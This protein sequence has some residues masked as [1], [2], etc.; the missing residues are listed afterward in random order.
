M[1]SNTLTLSLSKHV[2]PQASTQIKPLFIDFRSVFAVQVGCRANGKLIRI[3]AI[4]AIDAKR[5]E[6]AV[7]RLPVLPNRKAEI[8]RAVTGLLYVIQRAVPAQVD[9]PPPDQEPTETVDAESLAA[10]KELRDTQWVFYDF[11]EAWTNLS[12]KARDALTKRVRAAGMSGSDPDDLIEQFA[13]VADSM[14]AAAE[15]LEQPDRPAPA[16][17]PDDPALV[18]AQH[19]A[20]MYT[21]MTGK[22]APK[23]KGNAG[24][25]R[26]PFYWLL[27]DVFAAAGILASPDHYAKLI[28]HS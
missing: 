7:H 2:L 11:R 25:P 14:A 24:I 8:D 28:S 4:G 15:A 1:K 17:K 16:P 5:L 13:S 18:I 19:A 12:D 23:P 21:R 27:E 9:E 26:G 22:E 20:R 6:T 10:A 3:M